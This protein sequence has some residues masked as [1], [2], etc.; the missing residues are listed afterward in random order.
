[1]AK[2]IA[3]WRNGIALWRNG[4]ALWRNGI[5]LWRRNGE[6]NGEVIALWRNGIALWRRNGEK[7]AKKW[8]RT[9]RTQ[10]LFIGVLKG[11]PLYDIVGSSLQ[12]F[13]SYLHKILIY[14][15]S[16][17]DLSFLAHLVFVVVRY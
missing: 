9:W 12:F 3:L 11:I 13:Y 5:A 4:I 15:F 16:H 14:S 7:M 6:E 2:S 10:S 8:R 1:M 17:I